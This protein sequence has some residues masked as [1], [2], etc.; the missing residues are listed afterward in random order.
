MTMTNS[1]YR[2]SLLK[3][4]AGAAAASTFSGCMSPAQQRQ[5]TLLR[6]SREFNNDVRW[7][8][9]DTAAAQFERAEGVR[10]L[11]RVEL[12]SEELVIADHEMTSIK[13]EDG[14]T[15]AKTIAMFEWYTKR[16]PVIRKTSVAQ[17]WVFDQGAWQVTKQ[18]R[19]RG[20]RFPL[21]TEPLEAGANDDAGKGAPQDSPTA[22]PDTQPSSP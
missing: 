1:A 7:G 4:S 9:Y 6:L 12:V 15:K 22:Q 20:P 18:T 17:D 14:G 16:D 10:F 19:L 11:Q 8:R 5:D 2:R 21:V 3:F 13:F